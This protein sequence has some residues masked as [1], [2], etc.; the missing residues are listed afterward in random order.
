MS[1][2]AADLEKSLKTGFLNRG[3]DSQR[4][5]QPD[6]ILND[7]IKG[8][9]V[10]SYLLER[11]DVCDSFWLSAAFLTTSGLS[12]LHNSL[13]KF[14]DKDNG[15]GKIY[16]SDYLAFTQ[17]EALRRIRQFKNIDSRLLV[18][19]EFHGKGYLFK[20]GDQFDCL[21]G[22]S[23]LTA[24]ALTRND[25]LN[26]HFTASL[27]SKAITDFLGNFDNNFN[28]STPLSDELL[29]GY[30]KKYNA[31]N[32]MARDHLK[33]VHNDVHKQEPSGN[34]SVNK[35]SMSQIETNKLEAPPKVF[36]PNLLQREA[37][38]SLAALRSE[39]KDKALVI[40]A[41]ATGKTFLAAFDVQQFNAKRMLFVVHRFRI[42]SKARDTFKSIFGKT[43]SCGFY[44]G[45]KR[46]SNSDF[47]FSTIQTI[48]SDEHL[49]NFQ[50]DAFD[51]IVID[52]THRAGAGSYH[53]ILEYFKPKFLLGM[54]ATPERTDGYDIFS[55]FNHN[56]ACEIR[57][58][59]AMEEDLVC[60]FHYFGITDISVD[61][62]EIDEKSDFNKLIS[63]ERVNHIIKTLDEYGTDNGIRRGLVFCSRVE[64]AEALSNQF[65]CRGFK[66]R[67]LS[68][69]S[70]E[71]ERSDVMRRIEADKGPEKLDY[72]FSVDILNEG[73][74][75]PAINQVVM[76]RPT[77]S[78]IIFV[79]Q[80]G[81]GLRISSGKD[82]LTIIDFIGNY[83]KNYLIPVA[84]YGD[85]SLNKDTLRNLV[86]SG[87]SLI[88][89]SS[90]I[91][92]DEITKEKIYASIDATNLQTKKDLLND[93]K[94]LR[95]RLGYIPMMMDFVKQNSRDP[96]QYV[97]YSNSFYNFSFLQEEDHL[98][99]LPE[100]EKIL[101]EKLCKLVNNGVRGLDSF[102]LLELIKHDTVSNPDIVS[103]YQKIVKSK[104]DKNTFNSALNCVGLKFNTDRK[105][106]SG[107]TEPIADI[108]NYEILVCENNITRRGLSLSK[109]LENEVFKKYLTDS[110][111]YSLKIFLK[112]LEASVLDDG[113]IRYAKYRRLDVLRLLNWPTQPVMINVGGYQ[114]SKDK[115]NCPL[116]VTYKKSADISDTIKYEDAFISPDLFSHMSKGSR[117]LSSPEVGLW[118][119][120]IS[121][122]IRLP[123]FVKKSDDEGQDH[124]Y[125]GNLIYVEGSASEQIMSGDKN[126]SVVNLTYKIDEPVDQN[127]YRYLIS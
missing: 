68:G 87:S 73:I 24:T 8:S 20:I 48:N 122:N 71:D 91:N 58:P 39:G 51:Y 15:V 104:V 37:T 102:L 32:V 28:S 57:L 2:F 53:K 94:L 86:S 22:S 121:N 95:F 81:R 18:G 74:D 89:G 66:T 69:V 84:L 43:K 36:S 12:T 116:F 61:G 26:F 27:E 65:N 13:K 80:L 33:L 17:P 44:S 41:T 123:L 63:D 115:T 114:V 7:R 52:E 85:R 78:A 49:K 9:K 92:F 83:E 55:L 88:P 79:Q 108:F 126:K 29:E 100:F 23:N 30:S 59:R 99:K 106:S 19:K 14:S 82:Y 56:I 64:E 101:L 120:Q 38:N 112:K 96:Y 77:Q 62:E 3:F 47:I 31:T 35:G 25:E 4:Q 119:N 46:D 105:S 98:P 45:Q 107:A 1:E 118:T 50:P 67:A 124:Y 93:Y 75:I 113:F 10:L 40:S 103:A 127:L 125:I 97:E 90:T 34:D 11:L 5:M 72:I 16:V 54:T 6:F 110:A 60:P 117:T 111:E 42:A 76:L 21:I 70:T 109:A